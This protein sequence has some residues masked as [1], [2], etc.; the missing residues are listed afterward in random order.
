MSGSLCGKTASS[1]TPLI[2][3]ML[4]RLLPF[5][6]VSAMSLLKR[7]RAGV[8]ARPNLAERLRHAHGEGGPLDRCALLQPRARKPLW[9][10]HGDGGHAKRLR[11]E[12]HRRD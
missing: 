2:S 12:L 1:T 6:V 10:E 5:E 9:A 3:T 11:R 4:P 7:G 8:R